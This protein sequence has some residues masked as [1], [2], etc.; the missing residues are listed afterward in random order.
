MSFLLS[1]L[2]ILAADPPAKAE[3]NSIN[4]WLLIFGPPILLLFLLQTFF[5]Q[6]DAKEK[7]KRNEMVAGLKK[8][9]TVVTIGGII[10]SVVSISED[11]QTVTIKVDENTRL[12]MQAGAIRETVSRE[13]KDAEKS[14]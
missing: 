13:E 4:Q 8:N 1:N 2:I 10:G 3:G 11:K 14:S 5:G 12:K 6:N 9:D 7:A